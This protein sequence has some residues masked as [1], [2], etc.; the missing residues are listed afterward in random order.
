MKLEGKLS[1]HE[2]GQRVS[3]GVSLS[4]ES[5]NPPPFFSNTS[6]GSPRMLPFLIQRDGT[7]L[8]RGAPIKRKAM[9]CMFSAMLTRDRVGTYWLKTPM[10]QGVIQVE[11]APFVAVELD[12]RGTCGRQ[13]N[14]C[15]RTNMDELICVGPE[16]PL[17]CD[18]DRP[19]DEAASIP[20]VRVRD[21]EGAFPI[22][23]RITRAVH[24]ELAA[25]AVPG[26]VKGRPCLGVWSQDCFFPLSRPA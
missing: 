22:Q 15:F 23:A 16:Y 3:P 11:D 14:L 6:G 25:L 12:F 17:T 5:L 18:W 9:L 13:Q 4:P 19:S 26:H 8:Y 1:D 20:Y 24:Y 21:G 7:W 2:F 10:E